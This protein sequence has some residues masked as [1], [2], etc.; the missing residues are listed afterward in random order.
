MMNRRED[1]QRGFV[2]G[3]FVSLV[4]LLLWSLL[5]S[6]ATPPTASTPSSVSAWGPRL[7]VDVIL[8]CADENGQIALQQRATE[9]VGVAL[10]TAYVELGE[11][12]EH[13]AVRVVFESAGVSVRKEDC[14]QMHVYSD[15]R[16]DARSA[17]NVAVAVVCVARDCLPLRSRTDLQLFD[18]HSIP[19]Q[20][21]VFDHGVIVRDFFDKR[22]PIWRWLKQQPFSER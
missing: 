11:P 7:S 8:E 5:F 9:P 12:V 17:H 16:R 13:T 14:H 15:A 1:F 10:P 20:Y 2:F 19:W 3:C 18:K 21:F 4:V 22:W 6:T